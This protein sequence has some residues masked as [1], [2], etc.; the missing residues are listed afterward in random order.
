MQYHE[1]IARVQQYAGLDSRDTAQQTTEA[2]LA[3]LG[4]RLYRTERAKLQAQ[5]P[6][7]LHGA[8]FAQQPPEDTVRDMPHYPLEEF[9]NRA[10]GRIEDV[11]RPEAIKR[12]K[13]VVAVLQEAV[14]AGQLQDI[15]DQLTDD[16]DE[17]FTG[18]PET[19]PSF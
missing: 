17:L 7:E 3:T 15:R 4:E 12:A 6:K 14:S 11:R 19:S 5:L 2:V 18:P 8:L 9:Y 10:A 1:F 13:A 16:Y